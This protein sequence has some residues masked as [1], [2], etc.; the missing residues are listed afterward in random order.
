MRCLYFGKKNILHNACRCK[1]IIEYQK[2]SLHPKGKWRH[3]WVKSAEALTRAAELGHEGDRAIQEWDPPDEIGGTG[4]RRGLEIRVRHQDLVDVDEA[5]DLKPDT[6]WLNPPPEGHEVRI[7]I[8][9]ARALQ[10]GIIDVP[11]F[12]PFAGMSLP[13]GI[14]AVL[15][16]ETHAIEPRHGADL[17]RAVNYILAAAQEKGTDLSARCA[18]D[19][20]I[21]PQP[22]R[23]QDR[24]RH[25][26]ATHG[27]GLKVMD[28]H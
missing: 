6:I 24:L 26:K 12:T 10:P 18:A 5:K 7:G 4:L 27:T 13:N 14:A 25:R 8:F 9:V 20:R 23:Q 19:H 15:I 17:E 1:D 28:I 16:R 2:W 11:G 3:A 21:R 22:D